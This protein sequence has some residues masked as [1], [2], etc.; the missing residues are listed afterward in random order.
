[1]R[2]SHFHTPLFV[3]IFRLVQ[4]SFTMNSQLKSRTIPLN[5]KITSRTVRL[6]QHQVKNN[7]LRIGFYFKVIL[8]VPIRIQENLKIIVI[9]DNRIP[10][11][12]F[13]LDVILLQHGPYIEII[14]IPQHFGRSIITRFGK[15]FPTYIYKRRS[16][17]R[18]LPVCL[19]QF[20]IYFNFS[21]HTIAYIAFGKRQH[22]FIL[23]IQPLPP[24]LS[25]HCKCKQTTYQLFSHNR[26]FS[27]I[28]FN[29]LSRSPIQFD[30][31]VQQYGNYRNL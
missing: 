29:N 21:I 3:L 20:S 4:G 9:I 28:T 18:L 30:R 8:P 7:S 19:I 1:M 31:S 15:S 14:I 6:V 26:F 12:E 25:C 2:N 5:H 23:F 22:T 17:L 10:L 11:T 13:R 16:G 24:E 27:L